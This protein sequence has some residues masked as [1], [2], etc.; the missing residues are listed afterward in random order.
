MEDSKKNK[1]LYVISKNNEESTKLDLKDFFGDPNKYLESKSKFIVGIRHLF[2][3]RSSL[4]LKYTSKKSPQN[5]LIEKKEEENNELSCDTKNNQKPFYSFNKL[6]KHNKNR[7]I[8]KCFSSFTPKDTKNLAQIFK[9]LCPKKN[10]NYRNRLSFNSVS[11]KELSKNNLDSNLSLKPKDIHYE[12]KTKKEI[13]DIFEQFLKK[14]KEK[15]EMV[16]RPLSSQKPS[17]PPKKKISFIEIIKSKDKHKKY[18]NIFSKFLSKKCERDKNNLLVNRIDDF[19]KKKHMSNYLQENKL[20]S[21]R[22]GNKYWICSLRRSQTKNEYKI[23][24]VVTGKQDKEPWEQIIDSGKLEPEYI[25]D[26]SISE[27]KIL[28]NN[29]M[30]EYNI[31]NEKFP[32]LNS[33]KSLKI[34]GKN[35]LEKEFNNFSYNSGKYQNIKYR[36]Y[37]DPKELKEKNVKDIIYKQNYL[38]SYKNKKNIEIKN[39]RKKL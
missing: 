8:N 23:N 13:L 31:F 3:H 26:P 12:F 16:I 7:K 6:K 2:N 1:K 11:N 18:F 4:P 14:Q 34:E 25:N 19:N 38:S 37:K 24:Y 9:S 30:D 39:K 28:C 5:D 33:V 20:F 36:L 21:E 15:K 29:T 22:L 10:I 17:F 32:F 35:L 27:K